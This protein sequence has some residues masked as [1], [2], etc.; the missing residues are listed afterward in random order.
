MSDPNTDPSPRISD[1]EWD[2]MNS[3][4]EDPPRTAQQVCESLAP[5]KGWSDRTVKT[6]LGRLLKK[7]V[8][9]FEREGARYLYHPLRS[10]DECVR[11]EHR[12]LLERVHGGEASPM[13]AHFL[14]ESDL[15]SNEIEELKRILDEK[16]RGQ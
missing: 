12:S 1:A 4:W 8:L 14:R 11:Q 10:R 5:Q 3:I 7:G 16:E 6:L 15:S 9:G 13:L 2:V